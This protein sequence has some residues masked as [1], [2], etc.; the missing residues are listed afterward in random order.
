MRTIA[1]SYIE[2]GFNKGLVRGIE[3]GEVE[4]RGYKP[5]WKKPQVTCLNPTWFKI[6]FFCYW[7][8]Y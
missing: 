5:E 7:L 2:E 1:D 3:K 6:Y 4:K 8:A